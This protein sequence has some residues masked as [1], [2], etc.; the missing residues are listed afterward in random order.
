MH[1]SLAL[2][3][4]ISSHRVRVRKWL[5]ELVVDEAA[6]GEDGPLERL[7]NDTSEEV[8]TD[9]VLLF[10]PPYGLVDRSV[11]EWN[12]QKSIIV[13]TDV[14]VQAS[15][16]ASN[17]FPGRLRWIEVGIGDDSALGQRTHQSWDGLALIGGRGDE[18]WRLA[19]TGNI[20]EW[21]QNLTEA[22]VGN[23]QG[24]L[25]NIV[26]E[27]SDEDGNVFIFL[28]EALRQTLRAEKWEALC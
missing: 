10:T 4:K 1:G 23:L 2:T 14:D 21:N 19:I 22:Q 5:V 9:S 15:K 28:E 27:A 3:L 7:S 6:R 24:E 18:E 16:T 25:S 13:D 26:E 8:C 11:W 17:L 20:D 12:A